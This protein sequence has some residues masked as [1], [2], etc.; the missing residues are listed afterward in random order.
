MGGFELGNFICSSKEN[1]PTTSAHRGVR[2][3]LSQQANVRPA[4][5]LPDD[6]LHP[7]CVLIRRLDLGQELGRDLAEQVNARL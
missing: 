3:E 1:S 5:A 4:L 2:R 7:L 6:P